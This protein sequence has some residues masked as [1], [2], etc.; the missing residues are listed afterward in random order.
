MCV[1]FSQ[2]REE[3]QRREWWT[4]SGRR[5]DAENRAGT[6]DLFPGDGEQA[7]RLRGDTAQGHA[8]CAGPAEQPVQ[9][10]EAEETSPRQ[11]EVCKASASSLAAQQ[12]TLGQ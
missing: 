7:A 10:W 1:W 11:H 5:G 9:V 8:S 2:V 6:D 4:H 3:P 12:G